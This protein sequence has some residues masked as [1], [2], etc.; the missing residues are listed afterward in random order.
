MV[1]NIIVV[2]I[3]RI[4]RYIY[5]KLSAISYIKMEQLPDIGMEC[6]ILEYVDGIKIPEMKAGQEYSIIPI[7]PLEMSTLKIFLL[8][9]ATVLGSVGKRS[10][11]I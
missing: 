3:I 6:I 4:L 9:C 10:H 2:A 8:Y 5:Q 1:D 7:I 11:L